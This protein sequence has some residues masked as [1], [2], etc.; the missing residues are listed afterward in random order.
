MQGP[1]GSPCSRPTVGPPTL[2][3]SRSELRRARE[4][5]LEQVE[6]GPAVGVGRDLEPQ[7]LSSEAVGGRYVLSPPARDG[8]DELDPPAQHGLPKPRESAG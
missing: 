1:Y 7:S 6:A 8:Q 2:R 3:L 4:Q 5:L